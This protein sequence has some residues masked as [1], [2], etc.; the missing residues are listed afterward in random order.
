MAEEKPITVDELLNQ[1]NNLTMHSTAI[2]N[3]HFQD[4]DSKNNNNSDSEVFQK[5]YIGF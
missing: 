2:Q 3:L 4:G 5:L 1:G